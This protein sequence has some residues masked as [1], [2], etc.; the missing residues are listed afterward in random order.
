[1]RSQ[2]KIFTY[3]PSFFPFF[4]FLEHG[5]CLKDS[6][7]KIY[8]EI[9]RILTTSPRNFLI[10]ICS[11]SPLYHHHC[12]YH[13]CHPLIIITVPICITIVTGKTQPCLA[14]EYSG[15]ENWFVFFLSEN[16]DVQHL[17]HHI[18]QGLLVNTVSFEQRTV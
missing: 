4:V 17:K 1:M 3:Y 9:P 13:H 15:V 6:T 11:L 16:W 8:L 12:S 14:G 18:D 5:R 10:A 2:T 7:T